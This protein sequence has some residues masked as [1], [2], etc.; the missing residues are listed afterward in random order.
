MNFRD[1][2]RLLHT[3]RQLRPVQITNRIQRRLRSAT[4]SLSNP[5]VAR[6]QI[7]SWT[8]P[9]E[10]DPSLLDAR[11]QQVF[12]REIPLVTEAWNDPDLGHLTRYNLHYF[13][14]LN[15]ADASDRTL[16]HTDLITRWIQE[17]PPGVGT[18][19]EP[20]PLSIRIVNWIKWSLAGHELSDDAERSLAFQAR[21]LENQLEFHLLGN[22]LWANAKAL[23][24]AGFYFDGPEAAR[25]LR[26]G[27]ALLAR[28]LKEQILTDGGHFEL[29]PMYHSVLLEDLLDLVNLFRITAQDSESLAAPI[30]S[31]RRWLL[32]MCH[33]DGGISFFNDAAFGIAATAE[34]IRDYASRLQLPDV[35]LPHDRV[36]HLKDSGYIRVQFPKH[37]LLIDVAEIGPSYQPG[38]AHADTLCFEWSY[39]HE[40]VF[41]NSGTSCYGTSVERER[42]RGTSAHN[43]VIV[44]DTNSSDV[45]SGF[46]VG[47]RAHPFDLQIQTNPDDVKITCSHS[48]YQR[49]AGRVTHTRKWQIHGH[50]FSIQDDLSGRPDSAEARFHFHPAWTFH[51][52]NGGYEALSDAGR[53]FLQLGAHQPSELESSSFHPR[54]EVALPNQVLRVPIDGPKL[55]TEVSWHGKDD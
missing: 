39:G 51:E 20:Y 55:I 7:R 47:R 26:R 17:N 33:P 34:Q 37:V 44:D 29:S 54:F 8:P 40:R 1:L 11:T 49:L 42:Q 14:D 4:P 38:H 31:M 43:T 19:W 13:D 41:V 6:P 9:I 50:G 18:G 3:V 5:P 36:I 46:R 53:I 21:S 16:W 22:H 35:R 2:P 10:R 24:F 48:G 45:W 28:E 15:A 27:T 32:A 25:W 12:Q 30:Q 23:I 52:R